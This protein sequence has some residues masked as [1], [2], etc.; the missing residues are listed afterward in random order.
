MPTAPNED[1]Y[2][3]SRLE[4]KPSRVGEASA[5]A[6]QDNTVLEEIR[7]E[8]KVLHQEFNLPKRS[9]PQFDGNPKEYYRFTRCFEEFVMKQVD[10]PSQLECLIEM[11]SGKDHEAVKSFSIVKTQNPFPSC[12]FVA[13]GMCAELRT[14]ATSNNRDHPTRLIYHCLFVPHT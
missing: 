10:S 8:T 12:G 4:R 14:V 9:L 3:S 5:N 11:F 2:K 6:N 7:N 1:L 13:S